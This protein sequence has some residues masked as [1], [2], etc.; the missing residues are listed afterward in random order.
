MKNEY[1]M[2]WKLYRSWYRE[3][4]FRGWGLV[5]FILYT[6][7]LCADAVFCV[8]FLMQSIRSGGQFPYWYAMLLFWIG[9]FCAYRAYLR[10]YLIARQRYNFMVKTYGK[11][12]WMVRIVFG[13]KLIELHEPTAKQRLR[14][15][16]LISVTDR[17]NK[18]RLKFKNGVVVRLYKD[19]FVDSTWQECEEMLRAK[20]NEAPRQAE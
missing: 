16:D 9:L 19:A 5:F 14:Y 15:S 2:T 8:I 1:L 6:L 3:M 18:I 7:I 17:D 20:M 12:E 13:E 10:Y 11:T 4:R